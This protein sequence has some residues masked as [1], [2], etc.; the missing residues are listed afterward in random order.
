MPTSAQVHHYMNDCSCLSHHLCI[1]TPPP[2]PCLPCLGQWL[3]WQPRCRPARPTW[4]CTLASDAIFMPSLVIGRAGRCGAEGCS[5]VSLITCNILYLTHQGI[6]DAVHTHTHPAFDRCQLP[7][8]SQGALPAPA[9]VLLWQLS[10][11]RH[12]AMFVLSYHI[13]LFAAACIACFGGGRGCKSDILRSHALVDLPFE[14]LTGG[15]LPAA[16]EPNSEAGELEEACQLKSHVWIGSLL[17]M[18]VR[19]CH[20]DM[21]VGVRG[22]GTKARCV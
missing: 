3:V 10:G 6:K 22:W 11:R 16:P 21:W 4:P 14:I 5:G 17:H 18:M 12:L 2:P 7:G 19:W 1:H 13:S 9:G 15:L 20:D 8:G